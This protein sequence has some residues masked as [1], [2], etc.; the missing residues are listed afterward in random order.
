MFKYKCI[1]K[2]GDCMEE[3][4]VYD[5][6]EFKEQNILVSIKEVYKILENRG[7]NPTNQIVGYLMS[8]DP[9]YITSYKDAR[10]IILGFERSKIL[11][12]L[13]KEMIK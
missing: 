10:D 6:N 2:V 5:V 13:L 3:T 8:G 4:K 1:P 7:Y 9:G 11:E 12:V